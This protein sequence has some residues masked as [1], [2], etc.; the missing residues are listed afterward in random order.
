M[1][2]NLIGGL[3]RMGKTYAM[4]KIGYDALARGERVYSNFKLFVPEEIIG[5][6]AN[7]QDREDPNKQVFYWANLDELEHFTNGTILMDEAQRYF[8]ARQWAVLSP[9]VEMRLQQ[10]GKD[11]LDI[12]AT[13]QHHSR[14]DVSLRLL[15][16]EYHIAR[17]MFG[18]E[19][20]KKTGKYKWG[21]IP[22]GL[23]RMRTYTPE[24]I[25][26]VYTAPDERVP[27]PQ[28]TTWIWITKNNVARYDTTQKV[29]QSRP[30]PLRHVERWCS[31]DMCPKHG[32]S[33]PDAK[34]MIEHK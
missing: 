27:I 8:N 21:L 22:F 10:H 15:V 11:A 13:S 19:Y 23:I 34:P 12:W 33:H 6:W 31:D 24:D 3:P 28:Y 5:D 1:A 18:P 25:E 7:I 20:D 29:A 16:F 30:M 4:A 17:K 32:K 14:I 2:I 9:D 26:R